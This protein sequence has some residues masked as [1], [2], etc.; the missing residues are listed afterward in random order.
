M[1]VI[2]VH[3]ASLPGAPMSEK[4]IAVPALS[5]AI[6]GYPKREPRPPFLPRSISSS[7][8]AAGAAWPRHRSYPWVLHVRCAAPAAS[9][10]RARGICARLSDARTEIHA[11]RLMIA[12]I[13]LRKG[14]P[15]ARRITV[16]GSRFR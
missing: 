16:H 6:H 13:K 11:S 5:R 8:P 4:L 14:S 9:V 15:G 1:I 7:L 12:V 3:S 10:Y 2:P